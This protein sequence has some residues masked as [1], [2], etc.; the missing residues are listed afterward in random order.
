MRR[1]KCSCCSRARQKCLAVVAVSLIGFAAGPCPASGYAFGYVVGDMRQPA[2]ASGGTACPQRTR[3]AIAPAGINRQWSTSLAASPVTI[4]T[5]DQTAAGRLNEIESAINSGFG[6]WMGVSGS[7]LISSAFA[8]LART[9]VQ[10]ACNS[11]D[12]IN[13]IC[14]N[15]SDP[16]FTTGVLAFTRVTAADTIGETAGGETSGFVGQILDADI[17]L[18]P[19]DSSA[20]FATPQALASNPEAYDLESILTHELGH[21]FGLEHSSVWSAMMQPFVPSPG[22]FAGARPAA[23]SPDAPLADDDRTGLRALYPDPN[24]TVHIGSIR[25]RITPA[26]LLSLAGEDGVTGIFSAQ[27]VAIDASTGAVIAATQSGWSCS[28]PGPAVFDGSYVI[29]RLSAG[30][31]QSYEIY[32]EPFVGIESASDVASSLVKLCRNSA[33]DPGWPQMFACSIPAIN[34]NFSAQFH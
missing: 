9:G 17:Y 1:I 3:F 16:A 28:D 20:V 18:R 7:S 12:G 2:A 19:G 5:S 33:T 23:N 34:L 10:S 27:V 29:E 22:T 25:G 26:N 13:T 15:Q 8:T 6:V 11:T 30:A 31:S 32:A 24:D 4:L 21:F 14:M